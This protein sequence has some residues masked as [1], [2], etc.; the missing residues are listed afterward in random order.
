[1]TDTQR[2]NIADQ[3]AQYAHTLAKH[4]SPTIQDALG[5]P[6]SIGLLFKPQENMS[7]DEI[8]AHFWPIPD[9]KGPFILSHESLV[10]EHI[11]IKDG[12]LAGIIGWGGLRYVPRWWLTT[13]MIASV[14][15]SFDPELYETEWENNAWGSLLS[16]KLADL[17]YPHEGR[18]WQDWSKRK[19]E[20]HMARRESPR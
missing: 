4:T 2:E 14:V 19:L 18:A 20:A 5:I 17:G 3:V 9:S 13:A 8:Q 10:P 6:T 1:L 12:Q 7:P 15:Y 16:K 11:I